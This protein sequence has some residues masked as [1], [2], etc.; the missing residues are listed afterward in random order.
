MTNKESELLVKRILVALDTSAH[1]TAALKAA[2]ELAARLEAELQGIFVE[3]EN[4]L[5]LTGLSF[6]QQ[7]EQFSPVRRRLELRQMEREMS[8]CARRLERAFRTIAEE[9]GVQ[10][11]FRVV[12]GSV[13]DELLAAALEAD[14][15]FLGKAGHP[16]GH[17]RLGSTARTALQQASCATFV[18]HHRSRHHEHILAVYDGSPSAQ[19]ALAV[20]AAFRVEDGE[21]VGIVLQAPDPSSAEKL[22]HQVA[23]WLEDRQVPARFG[24]GASRNAA[25]LT[26]ALRALPY[27]TLILPAGGEL[28]E[29]PDLLHLLNEAM[30]SVLLVR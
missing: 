1:S 9:S 29:E 7:Q 5:R 8:V 11:S 13:P 23:A 18:V 26:Q 14:I 19:R 27:D 22:H 24:P 25:E 3:D 17:H 2:A 6:V 30:F 16:M 20:A 10:G 28:L 21:P 15:L 4:L 12:R